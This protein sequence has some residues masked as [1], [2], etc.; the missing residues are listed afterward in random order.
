MLHKSNLENW[1]FHKFK[2]S[3]DEPS[4]T[5]WW[6]PIRSRPQPQKWQ[7][8]RHNTERYHWKSTINSYKPINNTEYISTCKVV[9]REYIR[10]VLEGSDG[11]EDVDDDAENGSESGDDAKAPAHHQERVGSHSQPATTG[12]RG[13]STPL[14]PSSL[15]HFISGHFLEQ[16]IRFSSVD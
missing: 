7:S 5:W 15:L 9:E 12:S 14:A 2:I 10:S 3:E 4:R 1:Q 6:S 8:E 13:C 11:R 16:V